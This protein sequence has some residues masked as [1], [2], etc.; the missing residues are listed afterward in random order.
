MKYTPGPW[1]A[2]RLPTPKEVKAGLNP[3]F[4][5]VST[6]YP[7]ALCNG[8]RSIA[9]MTGEKVPALREANI[10]NARLIAA[11]PDLYEAL[12]YLTRSVEL[13]DAGN[14]YLS[15]ARAAIAKAEGRA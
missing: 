14:S 3:N 5:T 12:A 7:E 1:K 9:L 10:A 15:A 6:D 11:A 8:A 4:I 2:D 13:T